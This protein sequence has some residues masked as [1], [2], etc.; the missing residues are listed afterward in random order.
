MDPI[1]SNAKF[2]GRATE[3]LNHEFL[4]TECLHNWMPW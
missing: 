1:I 4:G 2:E 3:C